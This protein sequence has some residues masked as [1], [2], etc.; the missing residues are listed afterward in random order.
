MCESFTDWR[1]RYPILVKAAPIYVIAEID[2][3]GKAIRQPDQEASSDA[4]KLGQLASSIKGV[5]SLRE[6]LASVGISAGKVTICGAT[7]KAHML[8]GEL[9]EPKRSESFEGGKTHI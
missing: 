3:S 2:D 4:T 7:E 5:S 1:A 9:E 8:K 6:L